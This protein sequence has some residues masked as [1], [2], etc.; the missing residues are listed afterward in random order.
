MQKKNV[1]MFA[2]KNILDPQADLGQRSS[3]KITGKRSVVGKYS[4]LPVQREWINSYKCCSTPTHNTGLW[5]RNAAR[6]MPR[7]WKS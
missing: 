5:Y 7:I 1:F 6:L 2:L 4:V 3:S